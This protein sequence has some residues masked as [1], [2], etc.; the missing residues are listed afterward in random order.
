[1]EANREHIVHL[2]S[3][4]LDNLYLMKLIRAHREF[5]FHNRN[6]PKHPMNS[7]TTNAALNKF[8]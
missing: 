3:Q 8:G 4:A 2:S 6:D 5:M 7:Q 1:M